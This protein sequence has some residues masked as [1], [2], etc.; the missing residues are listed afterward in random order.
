MGESLRILFLTDLYKPF[1]GGAS[2]HQTELASRLA[3]RGHEIHVLASRLIG[4]PKVETSF[5]VTVERVGSWKAAGRY[6]IIAP[7]MLRAIEVSRSIDIIH[8][9]TFVATAPTSVAGRI[10][11]RPTVI[12]AFEVFDDLWLSL[13]PKPLLKGIGHRFVERLTLRLPVNKFVAISEYTRKRLRSIGIDFVR[14][15]TIY[16][17]VDYDFWSRS[18]AEPADFRNRNGLANRFVY[19]CY[20]RA[21]ITKGIDTLLRATEI[22]ASKL[23]EARL[24]LCMN[25]GEKYD[26][27]LRAIEASPILRRKVVL[28][29]NL[30]AAEVRNAIAAADMVVVPSISEGFGYSVAESCAMGTPVVATKAGAIPEVISGRHHLVPP[31]D[32]ISLADAIIR[33]AS[34]DWTVAPHKRFPWDDTVSL[35]EKCF[36]TFLDA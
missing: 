3:A 15:L 35:Y 34:G 28:Q 1:A 31:G 7:G 22:V 21:G 25:A 2:T 23:P 26:E 4:T 9:T 19:L 30:R 20:G 16:C 17:G 14:S 11:D 13:Y 12:T 27:H 18:R 33:G 6:S 36:R 29:S 32:P 5:G 24:L 8:G 10:C